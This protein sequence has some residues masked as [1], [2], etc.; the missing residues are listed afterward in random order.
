MVAP[1]CQMQCKRKHSRPGEAQK[2]T[3]QGACEKHAYGTF[4]SAH[5]VRVLERTSDVP[6]V[7]LEPLMEDRLDV[8]A[9]RGHRVGDILVRELLE[10]CRLACVVEPEHEDPELLLRLLELAEQRKQAHLFSQSF[11]LNGTASSTYNSLSLSH[12]PVAAA[13]ALRSSSVAS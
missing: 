8:E 3:K 1:H 13:V 5:A 6:H 10:R 9:L 12:S 4:T 7:Q 2:S 11:V